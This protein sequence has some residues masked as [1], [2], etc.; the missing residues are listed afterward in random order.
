MRA[1][2]RRSDRIAWVTHLD[3]PAPCTGFDSFL[4]ACRSTRSAARWHP[5]RLIAPCFARWQ[6]VSVGYDVTVMAVMHSSPRA[7][8]LEVLADRFEAVEHEAGSKKV[9]ITEH[10]AMSDEA[11]AVAFVRLLVADALP[12]G[13]TIT[14]VSSTPG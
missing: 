7:H 1:S 10:V 9:K 3:V 8:V 13:S 14:E 6:A 2:T 12:E 5:S 11:D 4:G